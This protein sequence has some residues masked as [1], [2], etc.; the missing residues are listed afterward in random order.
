VLLCIFKLVADLSQFMAVNPHRS[1]MLQASLFFAKAFFHSHLVIN[2]IDF[3]LCAFSALMLLVGRQYILYC[4]K[5]IFDR[6]EWWFVQVCQHPHSALRTGAADALTS[7]VK[8]TLSF[9][10]DP[11]VQSQPVSF[12][13]SYSWMQAR[14]SADSGNILTCPLDCVHVCLWSPEDIIWR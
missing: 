1:L 9:E 11:P 8:S 10:H 14:F 7:L 5:Y 4:I 13:F 3:C 12:V 2:L 6:A